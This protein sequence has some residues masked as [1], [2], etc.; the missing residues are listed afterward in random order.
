[1]K[2]TRLLS[3]LVWVCVGIATTPINAQEHWRKDIE[4]FMAKDTESGVQTHGILFVGSSTFNL[5]PDMATYFPGYTITNRGFGGSSMRDV[6]YFYEHLVKPYKPAQIFL[7]EGDNDL[8]NEHYTVD[9]FI[10]DVKC[11]IHLTRICFP[12]CEIHILSIKPSPVR[13]KAFD[14]YKEANARMSALCNQNPRLHFIDMW[15][16]MAGTQDQH[17]DSTAY[18]LEDRLHLNEAGY[19]RWAEVLTPYLLKQQ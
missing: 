9:E 12:E 11:F 4:T 1:M 3:L 6:L 18:F 2:L 5:W 13:Q 8:V 14:K 19:K 17:V 7:Y 15:P 10:N 16:L